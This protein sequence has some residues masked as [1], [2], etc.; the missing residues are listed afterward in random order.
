VLDLAKLKK[1][2]SIYFKEKAL[3]KTVAHAGGRG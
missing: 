2:D 3:K 1:G